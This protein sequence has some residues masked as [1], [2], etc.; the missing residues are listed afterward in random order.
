MYR[1]KTMKKETIKKAIHRTKKRKRNGLPLI[2]KRYYNKIPVEIAIDFENGQFIARSKDNPFVLGEGVHP[3]QAIE[4]F[5]HQL[6]AFMVNC[7]QTIA[8]NLQ[9]SER[10]GEIYEQFLQ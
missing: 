4:S 7:S 2:K 6:D 3:R 9:L 1:R 10:M 5:M 8:N